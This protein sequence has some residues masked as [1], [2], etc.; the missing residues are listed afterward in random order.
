[1]TEP[2][3]PVRPESSAGKSRMVGDIR[4]HAIDAGRIHLDGG[5][6]F[7]IVPKPL[8]ERRIPADS[9]NRIPLAMT[10]LLIEAP[11]ALV[12]ID[13]G[14][15]SKESDKTRD[16][17][18]VENPGDPSR[19]EDGIRQVGF[20]PEDID[21]VVLTHLHF[22]HVGG[23]T[24]LGPGGV[25]A[26]SFPRARHIV[27][28]G[29]L[30]FSGRNNERIRASYVQRNIVPLTEAGV[31]DLQ[32][33]DALLTR[34]VRLLRTPGHTPNHQSVLVESEGSTACYLADV[35]PTRA[36]IPLPWIMG[37]DLEP[38]V[39]LET[40]R[41]LWRRAREEDWLLIFEHDA[42]FV[43]GFLEEDLKTVRPA[44]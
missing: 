21:L 1:M 19:L 18:G 25:I 26:L 37:L 23:A 10:C 28:K 20:R 7:G 31:W 8:W 30:A 39:S 43:W 14:I 3:V 40:K 2:E 9:R 38:L 15:G 33:G 4:I 13:T 24:V 12:L 27:Q 17:Y 36:H 32:D 34:G 35:C 41:G 6:M 16:I 29:E 5:A 44:D 11:E 22:D 42:E